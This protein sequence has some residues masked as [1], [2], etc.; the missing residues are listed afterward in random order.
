MTDELDLLEKQLEVNDKRIKKLEEHK[1]SI[2]PELKNP[3][4]EKDYERLK[5]TMKRLEHNLQFEYKQHDKIIKVMRSK[6]KF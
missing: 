4:S 3:K 5:E 6:V 1:E 2:E